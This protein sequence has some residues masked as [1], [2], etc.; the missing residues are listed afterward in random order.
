MNENLVHGFKDTELRPEV[1]AIKPEAEAAR[2]GVE[3]TTV[4]N[5]GWMMV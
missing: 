2:L 1:E 3:A 5:Q 4:V